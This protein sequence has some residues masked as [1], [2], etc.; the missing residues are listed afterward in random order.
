[1]IS[2]K[3]VNT[4]QPVSGGGL[5]PIL[6]PGNHFLTIRG[7]ELRKD[8]NW[9]KYGDKIVLRMET[10]P[11]EGLKGLALDK[12]KPE[13]GTYAGQI[14]FVG[15][16]KF[17]FVDHTAD[18][19]TVYVRVDGIL[20]AIKTICEELKILDWFDKADGR[21]QTIEEFVAGFN[22]EAPYKGIFFYCAIYGREYLNGTY[23]NHDLYMPR[24]DRTL[25][26]PFSLSQEKVI[27]FFESAGIERLADKKGA[28][29]NTQN[30]ASGSTLPEG[31]GKA[32]PLTEPAKVLN[33]TQAEIDFQK[34]GERVRAEKEKADNAQFLKEMNADNP[35]EESNQGIIENNSENPYMPWD[36]GYATWKPG[37][38]GPQ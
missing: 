13:L 17:G 24:A 14:G 28:G 12:T 35:A 23:V 29:A 11:I 21:F 32:T 22:N 1:M 19:G 37:D 36:E 16:S 38:K 5:K 27:K 10:Q 20:S 2:T 18:N 6:S 25:G 33:Q 26:K 3:N 9:E 30:S 7:I 15:Y 34:E 31:T 4:E 8:K